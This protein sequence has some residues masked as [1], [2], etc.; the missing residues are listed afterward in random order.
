MKK[1]LTVKANYKGIDFQDSV[2][3][4]IGPDKVWHWERPLDLKSENGEFLGMDEVE[5]MVFEPH[6]LYILEVK[7]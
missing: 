2:I 4:T 3:I 1:R 6:L 7:R 5:E